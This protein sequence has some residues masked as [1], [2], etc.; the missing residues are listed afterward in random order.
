LPIYTDATQGY[1]YLT[2]HD[3]LKA[4]FSTIGIGGIGASIGWTDH[5]MQEVYP[6]LR[7]PKD[8][9]TDY[10]FSRRP[11][12]IVLALGTNDVA[13]YMATGKQVSHVKQGFADMLALIREKNPGTPVL[14]IHGM[15]VHE[16]SWL[17]REVV[18]DAGGTKS[19]V[20]E[21]C[22]PKYNSGG[23]GHPN[24]EEHALL[25]EDLAAYIKELMPSKI[26]TATTTTTTT[27]TTITTET[28]QQTTQ[29]TTTNQVGH[30]TTSTT[31]ATTTDEATQ[32]TTV[33]TTTA[34]EPTQGKTDLPTKFPWAP[35]AIGGAVLAAVVGG[36]L[37]ALR[38]RKKT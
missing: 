29:T 7:Y 6:K 21:L 37:L 28:S 26:T 16:A 36:F 19:G 4:D 11:D 10:D 30:I 24:A 38:K 17:I 13:R 15:M 34:T 31:V 1:A 22:L 2:A 32:A 9:N 3:H 23:N 27:K 20:Y 35:I 12:L 33:D 5:T 18:E 25:A 8:A 14:W